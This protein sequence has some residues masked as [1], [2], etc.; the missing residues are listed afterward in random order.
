MDGAEPLGMFIVAGV[1]FLIPCSLLSVAWS[2]SVKATRESE[3]AKW[4][5]YCVGAALL[6]ASTTTLTSAAFIFSWLLNGGSP[7]GLDPSPGL[8]KSLGPTIKWTLLASVALAVVGKGKGR[9]LVL[10]SVLADI[11]AVLMVFRLD[12]D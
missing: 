8:W 9:F 7:H 6:M 1:L 11:L 5:G 3:R 10:A 4:R 2:R 12:F